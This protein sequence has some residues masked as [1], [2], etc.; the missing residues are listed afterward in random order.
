MIG[1]AGASVFK[2]A[3]RVRTCLV[4]AAVVALP[5]AAVMSAQNPTFSAGAEA[6]RVDVLATDGERPILG[7]QPGDFRVL[8]NGVPQA[9]D[10]VTFE[11]APLN[12]VLAL[13][14]SRSVSGVELVRL[15][16]AARM[17]IGSLAAPDQAALLSFGSIVS[18]HVPLTS[19]AGRLIEALGADRPAGDTALIDASYGAMLLSESGAGRPIVVIFS[20][21][22]DTASFLTPDAVLETARRSD[23]VVYAVSTP[24][25][26]RDPFL[27]QL[28]AR[29]GG[30]L[31]DVNSAEE[32][33]QTFLGLLQEFRHRYLLSYTP[34]GVNT[35]GWH[36]LDVQV[37]SSHAKVRARPGYFRQ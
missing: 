15:K 34:K 17:V 14:M 32:F 7:L 31:V 28:C 24:A 9:V 26:R 8:D 10:L 35:T 22:V 33:R 19:D 3:S 20:D 13:D 2:R 27:E 16:A 23:A 12:V 37:T 36:A 18:S 11:T 21:G 1:T 5:A 25:A 29:T 30:R 4:L 6:V